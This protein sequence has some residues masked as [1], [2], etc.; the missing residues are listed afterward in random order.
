MPLVKPVEEREHRPSLSIINTRGIFRRCFSAA[1]REL[2]KIEADNQARGGVGR[3][4]ECAALVYVGEMNRA[5]R[6]KR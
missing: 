6:G 1:L 3:G 5:P 2:L 4:R